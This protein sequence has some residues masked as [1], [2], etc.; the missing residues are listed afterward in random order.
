VT[1]VAAF[2]IPNTRLLKATGTEATPDAVVLV[3]GARIAWGGPA[4][5]APSVPPDRLVDRCG[6][7]IPP[8]LK[9][10]GK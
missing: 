10:S 4:M 3:D 1:R 8:G 5:S 6:G 9:L 7:T 2:L